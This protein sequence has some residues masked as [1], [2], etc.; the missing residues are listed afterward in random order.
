M[1]KKSLIL[2]FALSLLFCPVSLASAIA[3][4]QEVYISDHCKEIKND[5][6]NVQKNDARIRVFL[7]GKYETIMTHFIV[8]LNMRLVEN[9]LSNADLVENQNELAEAKALFSNDYISYQ[10]S[11]ENL[12][13]MDCKSEPTAFYEQLTKVRKKRKIIEQDV[14]KMRSLLSTHINLVTELRGKL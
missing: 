8:P 9:S 2:C 14:L 7:G 13:A 10:Q 5:L 12:V 11:L 6:K 4:N 1:K 3:K